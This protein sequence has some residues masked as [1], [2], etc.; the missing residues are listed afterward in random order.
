MPEFITAYS[1]KFNYSA[2]IHTWY[3]WLHRLPSN[4]C[5]G[6]NYLAYRWQ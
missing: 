4:I 5:C 6:G 1:K 3:R 2:K